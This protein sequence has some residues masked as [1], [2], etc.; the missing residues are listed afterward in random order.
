MEKNYKNGIPNISGENLNKI[1]KESAS[2]RDIKPEIKKDIA[3]RFKENCKLFFSQLK[4][5][6][7]R[8]FC[9]NKFC[10]KSLSKNFHNFLDWVF[11]GGDKEILTEAI[12]I[13]KNSDCE[14]FICRKYSAQTENK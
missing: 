8:K 6:C 2:V 7:G 14:N 12:K 13:A 5:G 11:N 1:N 10:Q 9:Y 4:F 3:A